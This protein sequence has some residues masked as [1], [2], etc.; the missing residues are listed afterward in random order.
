MQDVEAAFG[1]RRSPLDCGGKAAA[2]TPATRDRS[3]S[4]GL[5]TAVQSAS[6]KSEERDVD[7]LSRYFFLVDDF[8]VADFF[9]AD[10]FA[11]FVVD[12]F[13]VAVFAGDFFTSPLSP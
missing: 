4:G 1:A 3:K 12:F 9:V 11:V 13:V 10:F 2:F 7:S 8:F 5:A 6:R